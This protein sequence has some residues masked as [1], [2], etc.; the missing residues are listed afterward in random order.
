MAKVNFGWLKT[1]NNEYFAPKS[2]LSQLYTD[3]GTPLSTYLNNTYSPRATVGDT[4][5]PVYMDNG[6]PIAC[7]DLL[8]TNITGIATALASIGTGDVITNLSVG[9]E[10]TPVYF[11]NGIPVACSGK[12]AFSITG[13][14]DGTAAA[15]TSKNIGNASIPVYFNA[16]GVPEACTSLDLNT[17]GSAAKLTTDAGS[18]VL[19]VYFSNGIPVQCNGTLEVSITGNAATS[20]DATNASNVLAATQTSTAIYVTG[21]TSTSAQKLQY[22]TNVKIE[23]NVLYGA[24]WN[25]YAEYR[26]QEQKLLPGFCVKSTDNGILNYTTKRLEP[27]EGVVS[28]TFGFAIGKTDECKTPLAVAGRVLVYTEEERENFHFGDAVCASAN[29]RVSKMTREEIKEYPD[30][31]IGIVSEIPDYEIWGEDNV[32]VNNRI[33][34]KVK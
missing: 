1:Y 28:D 17:T 15:L 23:G 19:P 6:V 20:T 13:N 14:A 9:K 33:W 30:R 18:N 4:K 32:A 22:N 5:N 27:C 24:A 21:T 12:L 31:I 29:G 7:G 25:D 8:Q 16:T 2:I 3:D 26:R 11:S 34:I 10:D